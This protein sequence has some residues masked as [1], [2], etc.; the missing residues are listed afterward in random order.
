M[1]VQIRSIVVRAKGSDYKFV[2]LVH[3]SDAPGEQMIEPEFYLEHARKVYEGTHFEIE[4]SESP[5][6]G[7]IDQ[8]VPIH[9]HKNP[10]SELSFICFTGQLSN[11]EAALVVMRVWAMGTVYA[12]VYKEDFA[13]LQAEHGTKFSEILGSAYDIAIAKDQVTW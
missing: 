8:E 11:L 13:S 4:L 2:F 7:R 12:L 1:V 6:W 10:A 3:R 5:A 9:I